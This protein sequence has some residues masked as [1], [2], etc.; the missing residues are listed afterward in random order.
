[1]VGGSNG[2]GTVGGDGGGLA[3]TSPTL[4]PAAQSLVIHFNTTLLA[5]DTLKLNPAKPWY[6]APSW[7]INQSYHSSHLSTSGGTLLY[8][9]T[10]PD[11]FCVEPM[12]LNSSFNSTTGQPDA[13]MSYCPAWAGGKGP[14]GL[15]Q[16]ATRMPNETGWIGWDSGWTM[17]SFEMASD[18]SI[19]VDLSP[20]KG[21]TPTA[22]RYAWGT[23]DC[24][25]MTDPDLYVTHGCIAECPIMSTS[26]L[27]ANPFI[28]K[29]V[30]GKCECVAPQV[31]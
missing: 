12:L 5:G 15:H 3:S 16:N 21:K 2:H 4:S 8:A 9:Q 29:I 20:L 25:D 22:V 28:A 24:C 11:S 7:W 30:G 31:C 18:S 6:A 17:L 27:P 26:Q 13:D 1:L 23:V 19:T 14:D 10:D